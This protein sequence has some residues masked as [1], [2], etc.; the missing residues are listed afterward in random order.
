[1]NETRSNPVW[2][3]FIRL[4]HWILAASILFAWWSV[5]QGGNWMDWHMRAGYLVL[6]LILFRLIWGFIGTSHARFADFVR[7][8][9]ATLN[10]TRALLGRREPHYSG[11]NPLGGWMVV[12]LLL[13]CLV[14]AGTGLFTTR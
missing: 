14:Q 2:D 1:M 9:G 5:E 12:I 10:Y 11:H 13:L 6:A 8:P 4:F 7:S 3:I